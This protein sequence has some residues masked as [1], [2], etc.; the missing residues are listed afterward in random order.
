MPTCNVAALETKSAGMRGI[1]AAIGGARLRNG[2]APVPKLANE[3]SLA[4]A[5]ESSFGEKGLGGMGRG[6]K[7]TSR[8]SYGG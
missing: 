1:P 5:G 7:G 3:N 4:S 2:K 8:H 6:G